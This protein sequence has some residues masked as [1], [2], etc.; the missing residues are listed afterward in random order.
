MNWTRLGV[1]AIAAWVVSI[2]LGYVANELVL[3]G[4]YEANRNALRPNADTMAMLPIGFAATFVGFFVMTYVFAKGY[5]GGSGAAEGVRFGF[6]VGLLLSCFAIVWEY[7]V[8]PISATMTVGMMLD[9]IIEFTIY[10]AIIG[11][12]Y[13]PREAA[14]AAAA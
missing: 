6:I 1:T 2:G 8:F 10:G 9:N 14:A 11:T 4:V 3:A 13:K 7:V 5:E 12:L